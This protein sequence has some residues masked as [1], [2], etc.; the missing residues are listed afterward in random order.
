MGIFSQPSIRFQNV[1]LFKKSLNLKK[2]ILGHCD[3]M[4]IGHYSNH[5]LCIMNLKP[6][7]PE[8][9]TLFLPIPTYSK[10]LVLATI[11]IADFKGYVV[12]FIN[13]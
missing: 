6:G 8:S 13:V 2:V 12:V 4:A 5:M 3:M 10:T 1:S 9:N 7:F 11:L